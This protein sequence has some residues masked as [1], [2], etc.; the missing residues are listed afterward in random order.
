VLIGF[1]RREQGFLV[2][3]GNPVKIGCV[4]DVVVKG[5]RMAQR[6]KGAG[7]QL[8]FLALL[9]QAK[10]PAEK[11]ATEPMCPTGPDVAQAIRAGRADCG[12]ATR[13]VAVSA[14]RDFVPA[15]WEPFDL[16]MR[17]RDYFGAPL[18]ALTRFL[19]TDTFR[20]RAG[21]LGGSDVAAAGEVRFVN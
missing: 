1:C 9:K 4:A 10:P 3:N 14:G 18:Q 19:R 13:S 15:L 12:I 16:L 5:A 17:Q 2:A 8:L 20:T 7:A 11:L 6:P 21:E